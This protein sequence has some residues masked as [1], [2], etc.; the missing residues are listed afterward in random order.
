MSSQQ[1]HQQ[2]LKERQK[3]RERQR[4]ARAAR[5]KA[6]EM[7][8]WHS[9]CVQ[10][11]ETYRRHF[12]LSNSNTATT[13]TTTGSNRDAASTPLQQ[14]PLLLRRSNGNTNTSGGSTTNTTTTTTTNN[15]SLDSVPLL[16]QQLIPAALHDVHEAEVPVRS[17]DAS[18]A[19]FRILCQKLQALAGSAAAAVSQP[20]YA[21][22]AECCLRQLVA[23]GRDRALLAV[24][25][26]TYGQQQCSSDNKTDSI[27]RSNSSNS[28]G[29]AEWFR[30]VVDGIFHLPPPTTT[31]G[32][33]HD[34]T[35]PSG[36]SASSS[37]PTL[38]AHEDL[39][40]L[41]P[42]RL[43]RSV[44]MSMATATHPAPL[45]QQQP[46]PSND[47]NQSN[48][49][50]LDSDD[51][52]TKG[53]HSRDQVAANRVVDLW[54]SLPPQW[55]PDVES[56]RIVLAALGRAGTLEHA[57]LGRQLYREHT[58]LQYG[59]PFAMVL[60]AYRQACRRAQQ[61]KQ[62]RVDVIANEAWTVLRQEWDRVLPK[63][64][65]E[66]IL[67]CSIVLHCLSMGTKASLG[68]NALIQTRHRANAISKAAL[69]GDSWTQLWKEMQSG[70]PK[71][72]AQTLP[73]INYLTQ[74]YA[75][76]TSTSTTNNQLVEN[77]R[78]MLHYM[79]HHGREGVGRFMVVPDAETCNVV[80]KALLRR[81]R[82]GAATPT[83]AAMKVTTTD[84]AASAITA[85]DNVDAITTSDDGEE[86]IATN[87]TLS[88]GTGYSLESDFA[89][90][91]RVL[92]YMYRRKEVE[93]WPNGT[94]YQLMFGFLDL[95]QPANL[96]ALAEEWLSLMEAKHFLSRDNLQQQQYNGNI[97]YSNVD[98]YA[99]TDLI[100]LS[101][102]R[103]VLQYLLKE[104]QMAATTTG[105]VSKNQD[106]SN[107]AEA[108][109]VDSIDSLPCVRAL[110]LLDR[111][112][113]QSTP[114]VL[115]ETWMR[116]RLPDLCD[117]DLKPNRAFFRLLL[118]ICAATT[119]D[120]ESAAAVA[121]EMYQR[122][123]AREEHHPDSKLDKLLM[124]CASALPES[125][126][127]RQE[128][129]AY[130]AY[131]KDIPT[132][133]LDE[134]QTATMSDEEEEAVL[135]SA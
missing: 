73:V 95:L 2:Q 32:G 66:R 90:A 80:L 53:S 104:A 130:V 16:L 31:T 114:W 107:N 75:A 57:R 7:W 100:R 64:R 39:Q 51:S 86:A 36:E 25:A 91:Q 4:L 88:T 9:Q 15:T 68:N 20:A 17:V 8:H 126:E 69:G 105:E 111:L 99:G 118:Q 1:H 43:V 128:I 83:T 59:V 37:S 48:A 56:L 45:E 78:R 35:H 125:S 46:Q 49:K 6:Q 19:D 54:D 131:L 94:T 21:D 127:T 33:D 26:Q 123:L 110:R 92:A 67:Q 22:L 13:S 112:V 28:S 93:C 87:T 133:N 132:G 52:A 30:K 71:V 121:L 3:S 11:A 38:Y 135:D 58:E 115:T 47:N 65:V 10:A 24:A 41:I 116:E 84:D 77:A 74:L 117:P 82:P 103:R 40:W 63:H 97:M 96:G 129:E 79:M 61:Q 109:N 27:R 55:T 29:V 119:T 76:G 106:D 108:S 18:E 120:R 62:K 50:S 5:E 44:L 102:Y 34:N 14:P 70:S 12:Q 89:F 124:R 72:D 113:V 42:P 134:S 122:C 101:T 81:N 60:E 85:D 98:Q 23:L